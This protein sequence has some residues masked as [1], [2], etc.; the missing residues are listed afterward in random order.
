[1]AVSLLGLAIDGLGDDFAIA[2]F[3]SNTRHEVH[4]QH[5]KGF[6]ERW[7]DTVKSR[8]AA[9]EAGYSTRMGA[10]LRHAAHYLGSRQADKKLLLVLTDGEPSDID[11]S[12]H[13]LL[14][15]DTRKAVQELDQDGIYSYCINLDPKA[16]EYVADIFGKNYMVI[17]RVERLPE[18]LPQLFMALTG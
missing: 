10:A 4:Y 5:I 8:L 7:D 13:K 17:D 12:D 18:K 6:S 9:M 15:Q 16:D 11:V 14:I 1:E 2:G 3:S